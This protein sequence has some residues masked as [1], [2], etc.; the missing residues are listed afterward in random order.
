MNDITKSYCYRQH[1]ERKQYERGSVVK[2]VYI[3]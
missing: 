2:Q 3:A 1:S